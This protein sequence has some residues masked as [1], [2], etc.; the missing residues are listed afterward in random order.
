MADVKECNVIMNAE[1]L[2]TQANRSEKHNRAM[3]A[4]HNIPEG[5]NC[6]Y[7]SRTGTINKIVEDC[8]G[9]N[10]R[11]VRIYGQ[12]TRQEGHLLLVRLGEAGIAAEYDQSTYLQDDHRI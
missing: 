6:H 2:R 12:L 8:S 3:V 10:V 11:R 4:V 7:R 9:R 1:Y 5:D